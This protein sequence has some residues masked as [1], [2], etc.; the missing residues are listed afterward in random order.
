MTDRLNAILS[1]IENGRGTADIGTDHGYIPIELARMGYEGRII[2]ADINSLPLQK[3]RQN[4]FS[5]GFE[6]K[7]DF[8]LSDGL[9][10][11]IEDE[12]D[13]I[14]IC[15]IG[16]S[17]ICDI[18]DRAEWTM[19]SSYK[20]ILQPMSKAEVLRYWLSNN[21]Y[22][23]EKDFTVLDGGTPFGIIC[24]R[25]SGINSFYSDAELYTGK[26]PSKEAVLHA[27]NYLSKKPDSKFWNNINT[28]LRDYYENLRNL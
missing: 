9:D 18:L 8:R 1:L 12:I 21:G 11:I 27:I 20:L 13:T 24:S 3:A 5:A 19:S 23:I 15:G 10:C 7:I 22:T 25:F 2:A 16:G 4:A 17:V 14:V 6:D 28:E 26:N